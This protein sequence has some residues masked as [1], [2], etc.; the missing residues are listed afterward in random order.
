MRAS[1]AGPQGGGQALRTHLQ[2]EGDGQHAAQ[3]ARQPLQ[4]PQQHPVAPLRPEVEV[5]LTGIEEGVGVGV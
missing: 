1:G 2:Q 5:G 4:V 3:R